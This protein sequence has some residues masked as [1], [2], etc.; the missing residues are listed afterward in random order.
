MHEK[1]RA[2]ATD[3]ASEFRDTAEADALR[4]TI[5]KVLA[6]YDAPFPNSFNLAWAMKMLRDAAN[7]R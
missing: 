2:Q 3:L 6:A 4:R 1:G 7:R 5:N